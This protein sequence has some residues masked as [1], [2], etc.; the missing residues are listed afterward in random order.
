M[1]DI[2]ECLRPDSRVYITRDRDCKK[3]FFYKDENPELF[4]GGIAYGKMEN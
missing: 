1:M 2:S 3:G 4:K